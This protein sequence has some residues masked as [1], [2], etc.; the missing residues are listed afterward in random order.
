MDAILYPTVVGQHAKA[1]KT[2]VIS[3]EIKTFF[4]IGGTNIYLF[5]NNFMK[6]I[7]ENLF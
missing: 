1:I 6:K 5:N 3:G 4:L 2:H 7:K